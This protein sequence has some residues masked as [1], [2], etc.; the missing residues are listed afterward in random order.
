MIIL[1]NGRRIHRRTAIHKIHKIMCQ[2]L[3]KCPNFNKNLQVV[4]PPEQ[5]RQSTRYRL[6]S[7]LVQLPR[8]IP[9]EYDEGID[10]PGRAARSKR[11]WWWKPG[12]KTRK[13]KIKPKCRDM[14]TDNDFNKFS[15]KS[16]LLPNCVN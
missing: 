16:S 10:G 4:D 5:S 13:A 2:T 12:K 8:C 1:P 14:F 9:L 15:L 7:T 3:C 11:Q 6:P